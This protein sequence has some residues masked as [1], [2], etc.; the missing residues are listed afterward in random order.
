MRI[1][2]DNSPVTYQG[3]VKRPKPDTVKT[4]Y[5]K[6]NIDLRTIYPTRP[7]SPPPPSREEKKF[8]KELKRLE[9]LRGK[10]QHPSRVVLTLL[11]VGCVS[12][13]ILF[14]AS[15]ACLT[16]GVVPLFAGVGTIC[17]IL[18]VFAFADQI[19]NREELVRRAN[20][21]SNFYD[22]YDGT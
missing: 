18:A 1:E 11:K 7:F 3:Q 8:Q 12:S 21:A 22:A 10:E 15:I 17:S 14:T 5:T 6:A 13:L 2:H 19:D 9:R 20:A 16:L 4:K